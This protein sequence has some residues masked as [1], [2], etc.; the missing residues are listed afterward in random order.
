MQTFLIVLVAFLYVTVLLFA[1]ASYCEE[2]KES[3]Y[4]FLI[5]AFW[6]FAGLFLYGYLAWEMI[7]E[8][9]YEVR[10]RLRAHFVSKKGDS[11]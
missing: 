10:W 9:I 11:A 8:A 1:Y 7:G 4:V 6:P 2:T 5:I 3:P